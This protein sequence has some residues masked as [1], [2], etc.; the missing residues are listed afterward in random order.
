MK[1]LKYILFIFIIGFISLNV[2]NAKEVNYN[3]YEVINVDNNRGSGFTKNDNID[4]CTKDNVKGVFRAI[5]W[6]IVIIKIIVPLVIIAFGV[7]EF[8]K[9]MVSSK[10]EEIKKAGKNLVIS[11][12]LGI[13]V[14]FIPAIISFVI[15]LVGGEDI[16]NESFGVCTNCM[17]NPGS[18]EIGK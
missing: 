7:I 4:F 3:S 15:G 1:N 10:E 2:V 12:I 16:Y 6:L 5:G 13:F 17:L 14:F 9:A 8:A 18:C 11:S